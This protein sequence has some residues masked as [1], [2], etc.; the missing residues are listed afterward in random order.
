M[1]IGLIS[2]RVPP[3]LISNSEDVT[4]ETDYGSVEVKIAEVAGHEVCFVGRHGPK[5]NLP[6]HKV[7]Y[8]GNI[9][10]LSAS[11]VD[12]IIS[13]GTVGSLN[14][15]MKPGHLVIP[16]DF[17][18]VTKHRSYSFYDD[19]R[20]HVDMSN[21]FCTTL[22]DEFIAQSKKIKSLSVHDHG[23]YL[24]TEGPRLETPAEITMYTSY[25]DVVG[26]TLTPEV[27]L[28]REKGVCYASLCVVCNMA[29]GLQKGL[30]ASEI[31]QIYDT[32]APMISTLIRDV[33]IAYDPEE[34]ACECQADLA[35]ASL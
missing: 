28:A 8:R 35:Q 2:G 17:I 6:P 20:V 31:V 18:D 27:I 21:P 26:M 19:K 30:P 29:A 1:K 24:V 10:A 16:H 5:R 7:N 4:I 9:Q 32:I 23:V 3:N 25:A 11:H 33:I 34:G 22:R 13:V 14:K 12:Y 15:T